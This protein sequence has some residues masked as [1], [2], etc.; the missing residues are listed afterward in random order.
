[1][2]AALLFVAAWCPLLLASADNSSTLP[3]GVLHVP[4]HNC[5]SGTPAAGLRDFKGTEAECKAK[6]VEL[7]P[8][9]C[10]G[11]VRVLH[12]TSGG[13][14]GKCFFRAGQLLPPDKAH[15]D[16]R[17]ADMDAARPPLPGQTPHRLSLAPAWRT[18]P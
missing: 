8:A 14:S 16:G 6:C 15:P 7:G 12:E 4:G 17:P 13:N 3:V 10:S 11:F 18:A 2:R 5:K 1:M 9:G